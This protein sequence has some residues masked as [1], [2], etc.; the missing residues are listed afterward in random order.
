MYAVKSANETAEGLSPGRK[1]G[2]WLMLR[3][4]RDLW[5]ETK[6]D[7]VDPTHRPHRTR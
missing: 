7:G 6:R 2:N 4:W 1:R 3:L 5:L